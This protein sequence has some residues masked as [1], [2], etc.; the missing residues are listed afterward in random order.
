MKK[1]KINIMPDYSKP[2]KVVVKVVGAQ[3]Y[4][5]FIPQKNEERKGVRA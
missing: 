4:A 3:Y 5:K 2:V 1:T